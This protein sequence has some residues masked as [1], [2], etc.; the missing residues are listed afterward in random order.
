MAGSGRLIDDLARAFAETERMPR[1]RAVA[2]LGSAVAAVVVPGWAQ[3]SRAG[4]SS[5]THAGRTTRAVNG[6]CSPPSIPCQN[7]PYYC[8][9]PG[10]TCC[11][12]NPHN[13]CASAGDCCAGGRQ[14]C[15]R[16]RGQFCCNYTNPAF[17]GCCDKGQ[18][19]A[20]SQCVDTC[21]PGTTKCG[22]NCCKAG[23]KCKNGKCCKL[24]AGPGSQCC[25]PATE[26]CCVDKK[27]C[28]KKA[29]EYCCAV[30][31]TTAT[32]ASTKST[33]CSKPGACL[34]ETLNVGGWNNSSTFTCC[35]PER[36]AGLANQPQFCCK[37]GQ[38]G[39]L[40]NKFT[41]PQGSDN[42]NPFCCDKTN[43]CGSDCCLTFN[44][45]G[46]PE[47]NQTCCNKTCVTLM[48]D[49]NN[50]GSCGHVCKSTETCKQESCVP[51]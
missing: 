26:N 7:D 3:A 14:C 16:K 31:A 39:T 48:K 11:P 10:T 50:C 36:Q 41:L 13:F 19:C 42:K 43:V 35:P 29:S 25:D 32:Y 46:T 18:L 17:P 24:C 44:T 12:T 33:C 23:Q 27:T 4:W 2:I 47:L 20:N 21:P 6:A 1:R 45:T 9:Q 5:V 28:C 30:G 37:E 40:S 38:V 51:A 34:R 8:R 22:R 15:D 49:T